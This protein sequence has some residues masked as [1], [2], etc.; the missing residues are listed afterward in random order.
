MC[1]QLNLGYLKPYWVNS[2]KFQV[3]GPIPDLW[4]SVVAS[5]ES[6]THRG[7]CGGTQQRKDCRFRGLLCFKD[8]RGCQKAS[9]LLFH[10]ELSFSVLPIFFF[11]AKFNYLYYVIILWK[12]VRNSAGIPNLLRNTHPREY[13]KQNK[14]KKKPSKTK[15]KQTKTK[16][17]NK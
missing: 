8:E 17:K 2:F 6:K 12:L 5:W 9:S 1:P 14:K 15:P 4:W 11:A 10:Q 13:T 16:P 7:M 3:W